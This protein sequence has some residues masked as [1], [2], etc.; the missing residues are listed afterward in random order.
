MDIVATASLNGMINKH[1]SF[2]CFVT[3]TAFFNSLNFAIWNK[4][5]WH[6]ETRFCLFNAAI[7][8]Y[9]PLPHLLKA[10][11]TQ[12]HLEEHT[13]EAASH[14][15]FC[16][17]LKL[18][19]KSDRLLRAAKFDRSQFGMRDRCNVVLP[20]EQGRRDGKHDLY[21]CASCCNLVRILLCR[22]YSSVV[23]M[24]YC[25]CRGSQQVTGVFS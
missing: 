10:I 16:I 3:T 13:A 23:L 2:S 17:R 25:S 19:P 11:T 8:Q 14:L 1:S 4:I 5:G 21:F 24:R 18:F 20:L 9:F 6:L 15:E 12:G 22:A 7:D